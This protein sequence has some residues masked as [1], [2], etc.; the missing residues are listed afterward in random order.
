MWLVDG[1][2]DQREGIDLE[3]KSEQ[4]VVGNSIRSLNKCLELK[5]LKPGRSYPLGRK[6][7]HPLQLVL[8]HPKI[9]GEH[10]T[11]IV[12]EHS[13]DSIVSH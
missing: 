7:K 3:K 4:V 6:L 2:F 12:G 10:I 8:S 11:F 5:L 13:V 9:S 1:A